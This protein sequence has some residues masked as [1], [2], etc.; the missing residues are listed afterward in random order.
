MLGLGGECVA[1]IRPPYYQ[2]PAGGK[3][4][5]MRTYYGA[6]LPDPVSHCRRPRPGGYGLPIIYGHQDH[7]RKPTARQAA[8][9]HRRCLL[10]PQAPVT[11]EL[12][13]QV[14]SNVAWGM[15]S[16]D[17]GTGLVSS[18]IVL[19]SS[20]HVAASPSRLAAVKITCP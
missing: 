19:A 14:T 6:E 9:L 11:L 18:R 2:F 17:G 15:A 20:S 3:I 8:H 7:V 5:S 4:T 16:Y 12:P 10:P 1:T 13:H